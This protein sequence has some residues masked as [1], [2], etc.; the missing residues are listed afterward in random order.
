MVIINHNISGELRCDLRICL[1][2]VLTAF[3]NRWDFAWSRKGL[4][5]SWVSEGEEA[6]HLS[7][8]PVCE[9]F[10]LISVTREWRE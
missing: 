10:Y 4:C 8:S 2:T 7:L 5:H 3:T 9:L 6:R 1:K